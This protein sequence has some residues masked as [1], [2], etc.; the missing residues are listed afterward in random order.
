VARIGVERSSVAGAFDGADI[1]I[2][3]EPV[4]SQSEGQAVAQALLDKLANGYIAA[5][6]VSD[7]NPSIRA[8]TSVQVSGL[9]QKFSGLYRVAAATHILRGGATYETHFANSAAH[10]LLGS[11]GGDRAGSSGGPTFGAQLVIGLVTNNDDPDDMG[12][13][14]VQY[15][16]LG[17]DTEGA[18]AAIASVSAGNARG[19]M[20]LPV[21]G[22]EVL[23]G[24]EHGDTRRPY[25]LGS[26]FNG[27]DLP[28]D[29]LTQSKDGSFAVLSD[30]KIV[31]TAKDAMNLTTN[32]S[33][34]VSADQNISETAQQSYTIESQ[35]GDISIK[36]DMGNVTIEGTQSVTIKCGGSS[37]QIGPSG[38]TVSGPMISLG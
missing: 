14:R 38:V 29:D 32:Q 12:R 36:A 19:L 17:P 15:P 30:Q 11:V 1:H 16:A 5:E 33:L 26:L 24:F 27:T 31:A 2:A 10:T 4:Q 21:V 22:E 37:I 8:G 25:I 13:V 6:G 23:V 28:G 35:Q 7:G 9:G 18:W 3:T 20:M 34:T